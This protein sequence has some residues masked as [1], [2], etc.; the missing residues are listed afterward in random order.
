VARIKVVL[1]DLGARKNDIITQSIQKNSF[2][3]LIPNCEEV[4]YEL[5]IH[6]G[7]EALSLN[8]TPNLGLVK[9]IPLTSF[10]NHLLKN[11]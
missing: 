2:T 5:E 6:V 10:P 7:E 8:L 1:E 4:V 9:K 3:H 11:V